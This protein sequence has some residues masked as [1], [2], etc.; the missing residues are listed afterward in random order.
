MAVGVLITTLLSATPGP[1]IQAA[2]QK[3]G[4]PRQAVGRAGQNCRQTRIVQGAWDG[5]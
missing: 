4:Y 2:V 3:A 1:P 5:L